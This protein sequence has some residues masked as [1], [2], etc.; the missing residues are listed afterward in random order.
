MRTHTH[1]LDTKGNLY[2]MLEDFGQRHNIA[3][4]KPELAAR[5]TK[6]VQQWHAQMQGELGKDERAF[7]IGHPDSVLTQVPARDGVASGNIQRSNKF[8]NCSF[9]GNWKD[10]DDAVTWKAEIGKAGK[11][12]VEMWYACEKDAVGTEVEL[13]FNGRAIRATLNQANPTGL[14]GAEHDRFPRVESYV[15]DFKPMELGVLELEKGAGELKLR[16]T[17]IPGDEA[18]ELRLLMF[19]RVE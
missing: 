18:M 12:A 4:Q 11:Y 9:F 13:S 19:R 7:I 14:E 17:K 15:K 10:V 1:R 16:A 5:L 6:A 2:D 3:R 8:P